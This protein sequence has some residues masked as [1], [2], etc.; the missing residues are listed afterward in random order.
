MELHVP[1]GDK[2]EPIGDIAKEI[3]GFD[4]GEVSHVSK[5]RQ[6][7]GTWLVSEGSWERTT[8]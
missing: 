3:L 2:W 8:K 5:V 6:D 1:P 4:P 7:N